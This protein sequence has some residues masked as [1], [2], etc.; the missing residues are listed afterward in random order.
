MFCLKKFVVIDT[1][2]CCDVTFHGLFP[3]WLADLLQFAIK[4]TCQPNISCLF[5]LQTLENRDTPLIQRWSNPL[6]VR[7]LNPSQEEHSE[8]PAYTAKTLQQ[9]QNLLSCCIKAELLLMLYL[10]Q[11][12]TWCT[13]Y[14]QLT[15]PA[16]R[17]AF[18]LLQVTRLAAAAAAA[19]AGPPDICRHGS[20]CTAVQACRGVRQDAATH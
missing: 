2:Q 17:L 20:C 18:H 4:S 12:R 9:S 19:A 10:Q 3:F 16:I 8:N 5:P 7:L 1:C 13:L 11:Q 15:M 14:L 6:K